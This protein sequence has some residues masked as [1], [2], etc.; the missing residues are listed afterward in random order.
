MRKLVCFAFL[1][2]CLYPVAAYAKPKEK[3]YKNTPTEVFEAALRTARE[4]HVVTYVDEKNLMMTF[5][6]G[7]SAFSY[8]FVAN[9]SVEQLPDGTTKL[10]INVQHKNNG[11]NVSYS[12]NAGDRM[13]NKFF[14]QVEEELARKP[15]QK[16]AVKSDAEHVDAPPGAKPTA[17]PEHAQNAT[18]SVNSTPEAADIAVDGSFMGNSPSTL[19]LSPG[20]HTIAVTAAGYRDW[21]RELTLAAGSEI[22]LSANLEKK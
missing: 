1:F 5:E 12:F 6:T 8:G 10:I 17:L 21:S 4:Q 20:K 7:V 2:S 13:A 16:V 19:K 9:A 15:T 14:E 11:K 18:V 22:T 3:I